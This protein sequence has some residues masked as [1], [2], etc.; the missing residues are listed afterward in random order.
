M[1]RGVFSSHN[2][3]GETW[4]FQTNVTSGSTFD[5]IVGF[6][7]GSD[8]VSWNL[9]IGGGYV[10]GNGLS[11]TYSGDTGTT[12][13]ITLR[14]NRLSKL[15]S[16][17]ANEDDVSGHVNFTGWDHMSFLQLHDNPSM[18]GITN[19]PS[20]NTISNYEVD[21]LQLPP[22]GLVGT[23]DVS[24]LSL[25]GWFFAGFQPLL[26]KI[27]HGSTTQPGGWGYY[28]IRTGGLTGNHDMSMFT[29]LGADFQVYGHSA[30]TGIT[31]TASTQVFTHYYA[32]N[33]NLT[34]NHDLS[35]FPNLGGDFR[36]NDN[37]KLTSITHTASTQ[38]FIRYYAHECDLT[39]NYDLS[40]FPNLGG[41]FQMYNNH[42]LTSL[43][44]TASTE[45]FDTYYAMNCD[46]TGNHDLSMFPNLGGD[47]RIYNNND[48]TSITHIT[49]PEVFTQYYANFCNL[50]GTHDLS[51][52]PS[53]GG[54][55][56][57]YVNN[58]LTGI[59]HTAS[60][61]IFTGYFANNCDL[62]GDHNMPFSNLGGEFSISN[63]ENLTSITHATS[64]EVFTSYTAYG[65]DLTGDHNMPF[66]NFGG[67]FLIHD[68]ENLTSITHAASPEV[69]TSYLAGDC[70]LTGNHDMSMLTGL[71]GYIMLLNN[72]N[73]TNIFFPLTTQTFENGT[74]SAF[75]RAF[76][77]HD[78]NLGY[79]N[80]LPL[81][82]AT[83]DVG[84]TYGAS[85]GLQDNGMS[86]EEVNHILVD[87]SGM[88]NTYNPA[89]WTGVTLD[90][91]GTNAPPDSS[92]GYDGIAA[93]TSLT[94]ASNNWNITTS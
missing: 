25:G 9:G 73:L 58:N 14:T 65:C 3:V 63:N 53:L 21:S 31:H 49:S 93:L 38:V 81:S 72:P 51:M 24:M 67:L 1:S 26:T 71:A 7:S 74:S 79:V 41:D 50:T 28:W 83:M 66:S 39:G 13:T 85:I 46:L 80:F 90:I 34:G 60:T 75:N 42:N 5:P 89:G 23:L 47:F 33:S 22:G 82:G 17:K 68:N 32:N 27:D 11:Y 84:S 6:S 16:F 54:V 15:T 2:K 76:T 18:T 43:T 62:T 92:G 70:D 87:F 57:I 88:S 77:L 45:I 35:M 20:V 64:P 48:L 61:E 8:R 78:C 52:F 19:T 56:Q 59:T 37:D 10:A 29:N 36:I 86:A 12:K 69:F 30:L 91:S 94:G 44:H 55:F 40:M 4:S